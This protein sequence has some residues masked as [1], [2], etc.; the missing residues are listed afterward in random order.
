MTNALAAATIALE[1]GIAVADVAARLAGAGAASPHRM[2]VTEL[3]GGVTVIDDSYNANPESM[4]AALKALVALAAG[5]RRSIAVLG[6][7]REL[8]EDALRQHDALGRLAVRLD[9]SRLVV[10]GDGA[11]AMYTGALLEG[12]FGE[13]ATFVSD[14]DE[15]QAWL[16]EH[17]EPGDV[18]LLKSSHGSGL[19]LLA[20]RVLATR[21]LGA[22]R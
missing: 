2:A 3:P 22:A 5:G 1:S 13:E 11:R 21:D 7:M 18:V 10:V 12:S 17:G 19:H 6:E 4:R 8:G 14:I 9:V 20:D 16:R 15:A